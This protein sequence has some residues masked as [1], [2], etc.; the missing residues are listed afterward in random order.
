MIE[1]H[2]VVASLLASYLAYCYLWSGSPDAGTRCVYFFYSLTRIIFFGGNKRRPLLL[3]DE[4][5][6]V[7]EGLRFTLKVEYHG[8][9]EVQ[10][11]FF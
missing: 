7:R 5:F 1:G 4:G 3:D 9:N 8:E 11:V 6:L 10:R 2:H